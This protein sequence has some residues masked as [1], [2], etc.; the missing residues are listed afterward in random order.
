M[1]TAWREFRTRILEDPDAYVI[2]LGD[3][4]NNGIRS[5][6]SNVYEE[7]LRPREQ[8][9]IITEML[10]PMRD[11]ILCAVPG[12]HERRSSREVDDDIT[13]DIM[14]KLDL[15]DLYREN[16]AFL[17][18][19][20][21]DT[22]GCG[23]DNPTYVL[24]ATHGSGG[25]ILTGSTVNRAERF[26][27]CIDGLD[28]LIQGHAHKPF[29]TQPGK[30]KVDAHNNKVS[31]KPFKVICATSWLSYGGYAAMK[32]LI[33]SSNAPQI[34]KLSGSHKEMKVEM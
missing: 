30:I 21:G 34:L 8:K 2:L 6:V 27:F 4:C 33:P 10:E 1:E 31:I 7:T 28:V 32:N 18:I 19:Q 12:N 17:K 5:S 9:R 16:I 20:F 26:A 3:L 22:K 25:G 29:V 13:Y 11:K 14:C 23:L 15:E 24:A